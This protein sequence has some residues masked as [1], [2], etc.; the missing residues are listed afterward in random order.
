VLL[1]PTKRSRKPTAK[2]MAV[3]EEEEES[4]G[5]DED[6]QARP[7]SQNS[8]NMSGNDGERVL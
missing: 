1:T 8:S 4:L 5:P 7:G 2:A 3:Q 6:P